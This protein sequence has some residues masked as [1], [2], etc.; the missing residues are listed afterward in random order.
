MHPR[1]SL[2]PPHLLFSKTFLSPHSSHHLSSL[3]YAPAHP[4]DLCDMMLPSLEQLSPTELVD[5]AAGLADLG[6]FPGGRGKRK[7]G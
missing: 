6:F 5:V 1:L 7:R 4:Q 2:R 3:F